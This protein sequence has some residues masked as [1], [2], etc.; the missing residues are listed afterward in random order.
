M[1]IDNNT[2]M[3]AGGGFF[4]HRTTLA[5]GESFTISANTGTVAAGPLDIEGTVDVAGTL[6]VV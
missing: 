6:V 1:I 4:I 3:S 5:S 2:T